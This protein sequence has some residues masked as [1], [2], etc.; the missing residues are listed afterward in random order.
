MDSFEIEEN[1]PSLGLRSFLE[2]RVK[3]TKIAVRDVCKRCD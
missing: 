2:V 1:M 3:V